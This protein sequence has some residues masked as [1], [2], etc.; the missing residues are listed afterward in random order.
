M[1]SF[2]SSFSIARKLAVLASLVVVGAV[3]G[4]ALLVA[5]AGSLGI[6]ARLGA[7]MA[8]LASAGLALWLAH[9]VSRRIGQ[10][11]DAVTGLANGG[12]RAA[13]PEMPS[14]EVAEMCAQLSAVWRRACETGRQQAQALAE[15]ASASD[16]ASAPAPLDQLIRS[17]I[18]CT[19][20]NLMVADPDGVIVYMNPVVRAMLTSRQAELRKVLPEFDVEKVV[21]TNFDA[22][23]R[24]PSHQ[25]NLLRRLQGVHKAQITVAGLHFG[26]QASPI[27]DE[28][29]RRIGSVVEWRDRTDEVR[30]Q[31]E[32]GVLVEA[33]A[34]G[35]FTCRIP[36]EGKDGFNR[37]LSVQ[38]NRLVETFVETLREVRSATLQLGAASDE[39]S[40][41]SQ[42]L[43][44]AAA[45]Q[46]ASVE[47]TT[48]ALQQIAESVNENA[49]NAAST[50][51]I[52]SAAS[53]EAT[54]GG[55][56][57]GRTVEAMRT[58]AGKIAIIDD[59]AYQTNLL[60][61]NAAIEAARAGEHGKGFA[62]V[63]AEVR[64]LAERSQVAAREIGDVATSSVELSENAGELLRR[65]VPQIGQ[66]CELVQQI[67]SASEDQSRNVKQINGAM[68]QLSSGSQQ[69][70]SASEEL[71]AT[72]E[73]LSAHA[74]QLQDVIERFRFDPT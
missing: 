61:L 8:A 20:S 60:A 7:G 37:D 40:Q 44:Q 5:N 58:I 25:Q 56:A 51:R 65:M 66:T 2:L 55:E 52:A 74:R 45:T 19:S 1:S 70:A 73:E 47:E 35:D 22:F 17:A 14:D 23:H 72:S 15:Q 31:K 30:A 26:L 29:G 57:V 27:H 48:A 28:R 62:V 18:D 4:G 24:N 67:S 39:V 46:A 50:D 10:L 9:S 41:T 49:R 6:W 64:K 11:Q 43:S 59:I 63:A 16:A 71:A 69:T 42:S 53:D 32:V 21:G 38:L 13:G 33:A 36:L 68:N 34:D 12:E 54:R 3:L